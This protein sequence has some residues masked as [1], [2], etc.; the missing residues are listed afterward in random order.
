MFSLWIEFT[1]AQ[2]IIELKASQNAK[3]N[4]RHIMSLFLLYFAS[5]EEKN[6]LIKCH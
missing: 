4:L 6:Q 1:V 3:K 2:D 5:I